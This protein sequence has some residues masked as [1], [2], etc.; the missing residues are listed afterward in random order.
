MTIKLSG[1]LH[2]L[3]ETKQITDKFRKREFVLSIPS[4][5]YTEHI[6]CELNGDNCAKLDNTKI[7]DQIYADCALRGKYYQK[8]DGTH[9][10]FQTVVAYKVEAV[11]MRPNIDSTY[12][13]QTDETPF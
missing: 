2:E 4:G 13:M 1:Q 3:S 10:H 9:A 6:K 5:N 12:S 11:S 7:G 8:K